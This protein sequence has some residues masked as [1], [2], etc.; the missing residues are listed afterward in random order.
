MDHNKQ[1]PKICAAKEKNIEKIEKS[2]R[3]N[4]LLATLSLF[5]I[6]G[7]I[8]FTSISSVFSDLEKQPFF[9]GNED[10]NLFQRLTDRIFSGTLFYHNYNFSSKNDTVITEKPSTDTGNIQDTPPPPIKD[11]PLASEIYAAQIALLK[12]NL[13]EYDHTKI[14]DG[15]FRRD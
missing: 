9:D 5:I 6:I 1:V 15:K 11:Y 14:P 12:K 13:Y 10:I 3:K 4:K 2:P 8:I 7:A